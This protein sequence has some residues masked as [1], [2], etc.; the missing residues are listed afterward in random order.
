[1]AGNL[2]ALAA[3]LGLLVIMLLAT[4]AWGMRARVPFFNSP[5]ALHR[6]AAY[7]AVVAVSLIAAALLPVQT[8]EQQRAQAQAD[9]AATAPER[10]GKVVGPALH[11]LLGFPEGAGGGG[12]SGF[13]G[14]S[15][16]DK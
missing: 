5:R 3:G 10:F 7:A 16:D 6:R 1:L 9:A 8:P 11:K 13:G 12:Q 2:S 15:K 14:P 4:N